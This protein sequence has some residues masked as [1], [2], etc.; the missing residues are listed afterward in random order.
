MNVVVVMIDSLRRDHVGCYG[1]DWIKTPNLDALATE[2]ARFTNAY[3]EALPTIQARRAIH[4][5]KRVFPFHGHQSMKGDTVPWAGWEPIRQERV[6]ASEIMAHAGYRTGLVADVYHQMK[7][8]MNFHRGFH[9]FAW[10]RGQEMDKY[11]PPSLASD[12]AV[13]QHMHPYFDGGPGMY[14]RSSLKQYLANV[15]DWRYEEDHFAPKVFTEAMHFVED[16]RQDDFFLF[17]DCFDPHEPWDP[18]QWYTDLYDPGYE[19]KDL[20][21]PPY[22][23]TGTL[24]RAEIDHIRALYAGEVTMT[25]KWF[26]LFVD[27]LHDL[28]LMDDT[29]LIVMSDHGHALGE[30]D[31]FGKLPPYQ[32]PELVDIIMMVRQPDG[33]GAGSVVDGFCYDHDVLPTLLAWTGIEAPLPLDGRN[34]LAMIDGDDSGRDFV[35]SGFGDFIRYQDR[36]H[37]FVSRNDR[38]EQRLFSI[39]DDPGLENDI[40]AANP[41][42]CRDL[43]DRVVEDAG[44]T[45]PQIGKEARRRV[46]PWWELNGPAESAAKVDEMFNPREEV[47]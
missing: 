32:Y 27:C 19:G 21:W 16:N 20:I 24:T 26:G 5:G 31:I 18:P 46:G 47:Q 36:E 41:D 30:R 40:A 1:N 43:F 14:R 10:V 11:R 22:G 4:T 25:D 15:S 37:Y 38:E 33:T 29:L 35:T 34:L 23:P 13:E 9:Q 39:T 42:L 2:S 44:G 6:T 28:H 8:S 3:P 17:V 45:L 12:V 7:P